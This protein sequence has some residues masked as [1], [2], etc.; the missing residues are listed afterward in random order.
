MGM[1]ADPDLNGAPQGFFP[2]Q[3]GHKLVYVNKSRRSYIFCI[4]FVLKLNYSRLIYG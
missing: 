2:F 4:V 1:C 3:E